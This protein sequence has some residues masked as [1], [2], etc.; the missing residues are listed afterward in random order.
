MGYDFNE[1]LLFWNLNNRL[2]EIILRTI[3]MDITADNE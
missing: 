2:D 1:I 3:W